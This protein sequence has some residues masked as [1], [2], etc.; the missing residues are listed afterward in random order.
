MRTGLFLLV[1]LS[2][3]A[4]CKSTRYT[5]KNYKGEQLV[6][7]TSGGVTGMMKEYVLL[8]NGKLFL[9]KGIDG[10]YREQMPM[11]RSQVRDIFDRADEL[12]FPAHR[13]DH[14]GNLTYYL[15]L[16]NPSRSYLVKWGEPG[17]SP[18][19][20]FNEFYQYLMSKF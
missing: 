14:P 3:L 11:K 6:A 16:K 7:G 13:F 19:D 1:L 2:L 20:G 12:N 9:S 18:P 17:V 5:P 15:I 10:D 4:G 8:D